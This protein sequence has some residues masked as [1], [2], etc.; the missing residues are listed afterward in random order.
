MYVSEADTKDSRILQQWSRKSRVVP[1]SEYSGSDW[2]LFVFVQHAMFMLFRVL[3][4]AFS[5]H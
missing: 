5:K 1:K 2:P 3:L 4:L